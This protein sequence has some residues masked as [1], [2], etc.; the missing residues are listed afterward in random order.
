MQCANPPREWRKFRDLSSKSRPPRR[1][2]SG[3]I[4]A[5]PGH[6]PAAISRIH[7]PLR[8]IARHREREQEVNFM[9][10]TG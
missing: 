10:E 4:G 2:P 9:V 8:P 7:S 6:Q 5:T 3:P 1:R